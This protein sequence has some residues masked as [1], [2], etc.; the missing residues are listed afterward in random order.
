MLLIA[1]VFLFKNST[2]S[3]TNL[4][5]NSSFETY[6]NPIDCNGGS[7]DVA[8]V[9]TLHH[10]VNN[11]YTINSPDYFN[12]ICNV[13]TSYYNIP[14]NLVGISYAITGDAYAGIYIYI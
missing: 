6:A 8:G 2:Y 1:F 14:N 9:P 11:W 13:S 5:Q 3:Q 4:I 12:S 7:F 10:V